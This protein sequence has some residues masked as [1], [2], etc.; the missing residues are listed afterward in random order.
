MGQNHRH[1]GV[2][3]AEG[4]AACSRELLLLAAILFGTVVPLASAMMDR[5]RCADRRHPVATAHPWARGRRRSRRTAVVP[6]GGTL[7]PLQ[8]GERSGVEF[9]GVPLDERRDR[10][11]RRENRNGLAVVDGRPT[12]APA[13]KSERPGGTTDDEMR[14]VIE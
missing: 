8:P 12:R 5:D 4:A 3:V 7:R 13:C 1:T 11:W 10:Q 9:G 6:A 2:G 14:V